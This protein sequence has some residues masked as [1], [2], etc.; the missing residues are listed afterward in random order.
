MVGGP[1]TA[2]LHQVL[3]QG[4]REPVALVSGSG[5]SLNSPVV[6]AASY[7][8]LIPDPAA[9][10]EQVAFHL[11]HPLPVCSFHSLGLDWIPDRSL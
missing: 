10:P 3:I 9:P 8:P 4:P 5:S 11:P 6:W 1:Q 2:L 7:L